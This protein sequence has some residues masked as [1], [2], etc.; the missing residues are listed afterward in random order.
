MQDKQ[1]IQELKFAFSKSVENGVIDLDRFFGTNQTLKVLRLE[2]LY[3]ETKGIIPPFRVS[4]FLILFVKKGS[5]KRHISHYTFDITDNSLVVVPKHIIHAASYKSKPTGYLLAFSPD[6]LLDQSFPYKLLNTKRVLKPS[7]KPFM[8]LNNEQAN[9]IT[10]IFEKIIEEC[11][12]GFEEKKQMVAL[13][14]LELLLVCDR[15]FLEQDECDCT[16]E[17]SDTM[18]TFNELIEENFRN[19]RDVQFYADAMHTHP[20]NLNHVVKKA[21]GLTAKQTITNRLIIETKYLLAST[22]LTI[23]EIAYDLGFEDPNYFISFF[24][25]EEKATPAQYRM[26]PV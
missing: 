24:K 21:T 14:L 4:D 11:N 6:F 23:K 26:Q 15:F 5:G 19:H 8:V 20:N 17:Y 16:L 10:A 13:K 25:R 1:L 2:D 9:E 18:E 12:S 22:N 7:L 3:V